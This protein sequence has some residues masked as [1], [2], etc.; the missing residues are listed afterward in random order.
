MTVN[1]YNRLVVWGL[2]A[3][4]GG[5]LVVAAEADAAVLCSINYCVASGADT[6]LLAFDST[7]Q[8]Q[9]GY[10]RGD[11]VV[12]WNTPGWSNDWIDALLVEPDGKILAGGY[13]YRKQQEFL[14]A[15][16]DAAGTPDAGFGQA[17][18]YVPDPYQYAHFTGRARLARG[19]DGRLA[20]AAGIAYGTFGSVAGVS[21][22]R[23]S[24]SGA[25]LGGFTPELTSP[26]YANADIALAAGSGGRIYYAQGGTLEARLPDGSLDASFGNGGKISVP[27]PEIETGRVDPTSHAA[28][29]VAA[30]ETITLA[31]STVAGPWVY[32]FTAAG[33]PIQGFGEAGIFRYAKPRGPVYGIVVPRIWLFGLADG[34]LLLGYA[35]YFITNAA[36]N[37][38]SQFVVLRVSAEGRLNRANTFS[39][40]ANWNIAALPDGS[41]AIT[42]DQAL[43][44]M[45]ADGGFDLS[46][47]AGGAF[48]LPVSW[49]NTLGVDASGRLLVAGQDATSAVLQRYRLDANVNSVPVVEFYNSNLN[50][51]FVT[52]GPGEI[53]AIE[54]GAAG[55][56]WS[57]TGLGFRAYAPESGV[58]IGAQ[59]VCRFYGTPGRGPNSHFYTVDA[60]ECALVKNDPGWTYEGIAFYL[61]APSSGQCAAG[62]QPV[63]RAYNMRFAQNDSNHRYTTDA[64][65]YAQ[66]QALG[67]AGEGVKFC[68]AQ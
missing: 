43:Y 26:N 13:T 49:V 55:S 11:G 48:A 32:K 64:A 17:G 16:F 24:N 34:E 20:V 47:G 53:A 38:E 65:V 46:F 60:T 68:G 51:Y 3:S 66:M 5:G 57:R 14:V 59:P 56:G 41:A 8:W 61:F 28:L 7:G 25:P 58:P 40:N 33:A 67:W 18:R 1:G 12:I 6:A 23:L 10:G 36:G 62:T 50:H 31:L 30:D 39:G 19:P 37:E 35:G 2:F 27:L 52:G 29:F 63:Y 9:Q 4:P 42:Q 15:Q 21:A 22:F 54:S 44:R 45:L